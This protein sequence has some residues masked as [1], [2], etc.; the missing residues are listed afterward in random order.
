MSDKC[1]FNWSIECTEACNDYNTCTRRLRTQESKE[2]W[3][4]KTLI[5]IV[6][7]AIDWLLT[8][9]TTMFMWNNIL[10]HFF[11][12]DT[13]NMLE[14][15]AISIF[16]MWF[17]VPDHD[18]KTDDWVKRLVVDIFYTLICLGIAYIAVLML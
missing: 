3:N 18:K 11:E 17:R 14:A 1:R 15:W 5:C 13:I 8:Q 16:V 6:L 12:V 2:D 7:Y 4:M 10:I 9:F